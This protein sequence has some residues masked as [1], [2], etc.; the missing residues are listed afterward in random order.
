MH[1]MCFDQTCLLL[2]RLIPSR[3]APYPHPSLF[4][5]F[6]NNLLIQI[7]VVPI[8]DKRLTSDQTLRESWLSHHHQLPITPQLGARA[9]HPFPSAG[10]LVILSLVLSWVHCSICELTRAEVLPYPEGIV[11]SYSSRLLALTVI[12]LQLPQK[13]LNLV[14]PM[15][16]WYS[17]T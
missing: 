17:F 6:L 9:H 12:S 13:S 10:M 16:A 8:R 4:L 1:K 2:S 15:W 14:G 7:G 3:L 5:F 11:W